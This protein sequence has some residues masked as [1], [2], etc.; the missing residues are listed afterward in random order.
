MENPKPGIYFDVR[1]E[2][3]KSWPAINNSVLKIL[4]DD[5][6]C[7]A[8]AKFYMDNGRPDTPALAFGRALDCFILEPTRFV[9]LYN[10][11]PDCDKRT[12]EGKAIAAEFESAKQPHQEIIT[13]SNYTDIIAIASSVMQSQA[14]RLIR[15]GKSQVCLVWI[16]DETGLTCKARL[17]YWQESIP[18]ITDLKSTQDASP[19]GFGFDVFKYGYY[20]QA[21][22]YCMG[23]EKLTGYDTCFAIFAIEKDEPF[24]HSTFELGPKTIQ[25]GRNA[26]RSALRKYKECLDSGTWPQYS[27]KIVMLDMPS[28][29]IQK[30]GVA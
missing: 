5:R 1:F 4:S 22:F 10:V 9:E 16:D 3:Y 26:A 17:D 12:K 8:H 29:A 21:G 24:V 27:D 23:A 15:G 20:Q 2:D 28:W 6:R 25:A 19:D 11:C 7:P 18:M 14:M 30:N 13:Q